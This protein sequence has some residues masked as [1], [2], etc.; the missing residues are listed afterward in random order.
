M[1]EAIRS[2]VRPI[3]TFGVVAALIYGFVAKLIATDVFLP[4]VTVIIGFWFAERTA[5]KKIE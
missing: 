4:V 1:I 2:L 5:E 3:V